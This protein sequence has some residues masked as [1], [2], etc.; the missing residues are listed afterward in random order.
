MGIPC[1]FLILAYVWIFVKIKKYRKQLLI[2]CLSRQHKENPDRGGEKSRT[3][4]LIEQ[5]AETELSQCGS[6]VSLQT[7]LGNRFSV[8][9]LEHTI[10]P[11]DMSDLQVPFATTP[12][13][14]IP[15]DFC[16]DLTS[17]AQG[18]MSGITEENVYNIT[19][20][21]FADHVDAR[22]SDVDDRNEK[23]KKSK[24]SRK[25]SS[26]SRK[27]S[28]E[29]R[30]KSAESRKKSAESRVSSHSSRRNIFQKN[31]IRKSESE[32]RKIK[33]NLLVNEMVLT[34]CG[35]LLLLLY[36]ICYIPYVIA[37]TSNYLHSIPGWFQRMALWLVV[38]NSLISPLI[39]G[40]YNPLLRKD[41][42]RVC[43][44]WKRIINFR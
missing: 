42:A 2:S 13:F 16:H 44:C 19:D 12:A 11:D 28:A 27:K 41:L 40:F 14:T 34:K 23:R 8:S 3:I 1:V 10:L 43:S 6:E 25:K 36:L 22:K 7:N 20:S 9:Y 29:S 30:K 21:T 31:P 33:N 4:D 18:R 26:E 32:K 37:N 17:T 38:S 15:F 24:E 35:A 39:N 5:L